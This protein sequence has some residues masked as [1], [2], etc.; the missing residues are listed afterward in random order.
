MSDSNNEDT[1]KP[2]SDPSRSQTLPDNYIDCEVA[3]D[4]L[5]QVYKQTKSPKERAGMLT[6]TMRAIL[7]TGRIPPLE[8]Y[9]ETIWFN[10]ETMIEDMVARQLAEL[11][12]ELYE[13]DV[14]VLVKGDGSCLFYALSMAFYGDPTHRDDIR[15]VLKSIILYYAFKITFQIL[16]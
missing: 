10:P 16:F 14:P 13:Q 7:K 3:V 9:R 15:C 1:R 4:Q 12:N 8:N 5:H 6:A 11:G 2:E